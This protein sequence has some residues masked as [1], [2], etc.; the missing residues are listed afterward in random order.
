[1]TPDTCQPPL[2]APFT[3]LVDDRE[4]LPYDFA[5]FHA[6]AKEGHTLLEVPVRRKR[7]ETGDYSIEG[8]EGQVIVERKSLHD[9]YSTLGQGRDRFKAEHERM[10]QVPKARVVIEATYEDVLFRPPSL[11]RLNPK[12]VHRT[13]LAW[14]IR[15]GVP[16][17]FAGSRDLAHLYTFRFLQYAWREHQRPP[18]ETPSDN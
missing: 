10:A 1:M 17:F 15:F 3:I 18:W 2:V 12:S 5:G 7:L 9:L 11:S 16:W 4:G 8:L 6:G 14:S 13:M